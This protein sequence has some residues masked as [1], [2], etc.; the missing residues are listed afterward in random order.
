MLMQWSPLGIFLRQQAFFA[1]AMIQAAQSSRQYAAPTNMSLDERTR[2][3]AR[4]AFEVRTSDR[5][6]VGAVRVGPSHST[7]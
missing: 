1:D 4:Q 6:R 7:R 5:L 3:S 2:I